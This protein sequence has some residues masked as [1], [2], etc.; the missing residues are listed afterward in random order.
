MR[1]D[2]PAVVYQYDTTTL[3]GPGWAAWV[4]ER[5]NLVLERFHGPGARE[6]P[7]LPWPLEPFCPS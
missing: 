2:G 7:V 6:E 5:R 1:F 4:D 3:V